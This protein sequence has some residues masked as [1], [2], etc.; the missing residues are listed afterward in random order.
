MGR[1]LRVDEELKVWKG[2]GRHFTLREVVTENE[3]E[4]EKGRE[5]RRVGEREIGTLTLSSKQQGDASDYK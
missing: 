5:R 3:R 1:N 2:V 4:R